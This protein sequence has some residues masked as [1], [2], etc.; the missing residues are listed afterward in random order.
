[1]GYTTDY[2]KLSGVVTLPDGNCATTFVYAGRTLSEEDGKKFKNPNIKGLLYAQC[3]PQMFKNETVA[4]K[5]TFVFP[6]GS[7]SGEDVDQVVLAN[8]IQTFHSHPHLS[9]YATHGWS[10]IVLRINRNLWRKIEKKQY[11]YLDF[12]SLPVRGYDDSYFLASDIDEGDEVTIHHFSEVGKREET[13][14]V[15]QHMHKSVGEIVFISESLFLTTAKVENGAAGA[16][17]MARKT[18]I[19]IVYA[20]VRNKQTQEVVYT[21]VRRIALND[22]IRHYAMEVNEKERRKMLTTMPKPPMNDSWQAEVMAALED[23]KKYPDLAY[24]SPMKLDE[25]LIKNPRQKLLTSAQFEELKFMKDRDLKFELLDYV[26]YLKGVPESFRGKPTIK[27]ENVMKL[28]RR[29]EKLFMRYLVKK[30]KYPLACVHLDAGLALQFSPQHIR[31]LLVYYVR[32]SD[33]KPRKD[34][35]FP[36]MFLVGHA[37]GSESSFYTNQKDYRDS[38]RLP[39]F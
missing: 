18:W 24:D 6:F 34:K 15:N 36:D 33:V 21:V 13:T 12:E 32:Q 16:G 35:K 3:A 4:R 7:F 38:C 39:E 28:V 11:A 27:I 1:M 19:G 25:I 5:S 26:K 9:V 8:D 31:S 17:V 23:I 29:N 14:L 30:G 37:V 22:L 10:I 2:D 20:V